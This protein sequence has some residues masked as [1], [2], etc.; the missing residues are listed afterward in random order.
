M[1]LLQARAENTT[2]LRAKG[3]CLAKFYVE[4]KKKPKKENFPIRLWFSPQSYIR[5]HGDVAF[6]PRGLELGAND[7]EFW[8]SMKPKEIGNSYFWGKWDDG[9]GFGELKI[10]PKLLLEAF[11]II[12]FTDRRQWS[13]SEQG[14]FDIL[15]KYDSQGRLINKVYIYNCDYRI[16]K[17]EYFD[18]NFEPVIVVELSGYKNVDDGFMVP[19]VINITH[20]NDNNSSDSFEITLESVK[21][22]ETQPTGIFV[23]PE[24]K[25]FKKVFRVIDG[26]VLEQQQ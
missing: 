26:T 14:R 4:G 13:L 11:G 1:N 16:E 3:K 19:G 21:L 6:N 9:D 10:N 18:K 12:E 22:V 24:P 7:D 17:I 23:R 5:L 15:E 25:G 8:F 20:C 2:P